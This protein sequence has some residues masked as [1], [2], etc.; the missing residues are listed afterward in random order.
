MGAYIL[1]RLALMIPTLFGILLVNFLLV[2]FMPGGPVEQIIA[3]LQDQASATDRIPAASTS[4]K[5]TPTAPFTWTSTRPGVSS[6][7]DRT[8]APGGAS[9]VVTSTMRPSLIRTEAGPTIVR[10]SKARGAATTASKI[11]P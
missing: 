1:R 10:P 7:S 9:P 4:A 5:S 11:P 8:S 3:Q 2:Q 6:P